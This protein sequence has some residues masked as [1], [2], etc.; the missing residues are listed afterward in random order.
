MENNT[1]QLNEHQ[2]NVII[3]Y[4]LKEY[5]KEAVIAITK[6]DA[7]PLENLHKDPNNYFKVDEHIV[8][9]EL[10]TIA[11]VHSHII[12]L[13]NPRPEFRGVYVDP[14]VPSKM[15]MM[16]QVAMDIPFGIVSCDGNEVSGVLWF[17][18]LDAPLLGRQYISNV[19]DCFSLLR[20][21]YWQNYNIVIPENPREY[22]FW[23][24]SPNE[25]LDKYSKF[26]F[27]ETNDELKE[28]DVLVLCIM[29]NYTSHLGIYIG[30]GKFIHHMTDQLS[31]EEYLVK[32]E[33]QIVKKLRYKGK[34]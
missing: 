6:D 8:C 1:M 21:Y 28:G 2:T 5:P 9:H 23:R 26:C 3:E 29:G 17:P 20:S 15:D 4:C 11:L 7:I 27:K 10:D 34:L 32:W 14:R 33:K 31:K 19:Y 18:D 24:E 25:V 30:G 22:A 16:S 12:D 13:N